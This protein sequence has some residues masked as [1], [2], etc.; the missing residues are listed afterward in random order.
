MIYA[1]G[2]TEGCFLGE[3]LRV[4]HTGI[5]WEMPVVHQDGR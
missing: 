5:F 2:L 1:H 4:D 3:I